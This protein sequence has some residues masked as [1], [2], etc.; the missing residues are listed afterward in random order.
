MTDSYINQQDKGWLTNLC[1]STLSDLVESLCVNPL[2]TS[3][4]FNVELGEFI[5][6]VFVELAADEPLLSLYSE[7]EFTIGT[8]V[9]SSIQIN[10]FKFR[11]LEVF[12]HNL[13]NNRPIV[14]SAYQKI[15]FLISQPKHMLCVLKRTISM[16]RLF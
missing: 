5:G 13:Y 15:N 3:L 12:V 2:M 8:E 1:L 6:D 7:I 10:T 4:F 16:R 9:D 11:K 14:K